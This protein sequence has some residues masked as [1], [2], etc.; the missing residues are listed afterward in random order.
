MK[1]QFFTALLVAGTMMS[2]ALTAQAKDMDIA[3][4]DVQAVF[5]QTDLAQTV[6]KELKEKSEDMRKRL[7]K[8]D[9]DLAEREE[10]LRQKRTAMTEEK[11]MEEVAELRRVSRE[12][13]ADFQAEQDKLRAKQRTLNK[14][15]TSEIKDV[16][17]KLAKDQGFKMVVGRAYL[18]YA[19]ESVDITSKVVEGVNKSLKNSKNEE[20]L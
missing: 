1:K 2:V 13:R 4:L 3:V 20:G 14:K 10:T 5:E 16:V 19:D 11:F 15:L 17:E 8:V 12:Y 6:S 9:A 18:I 7:E